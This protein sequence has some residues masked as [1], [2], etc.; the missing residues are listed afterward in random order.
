MSSA[1]LVYLRLAYASTADKATSER[2]TSIEVWAI[3]AIHANSAAY[4]IL[5]LVGAVFHAA[6]HVAVACPAD[7]GETTLPYQGVERTLCEFF[8]KSTHA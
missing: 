8:R 5:H 4:C 1:A 6:Q 3:D 2:P 7:Y